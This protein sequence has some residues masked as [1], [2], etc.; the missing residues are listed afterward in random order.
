MESRREISIA[1]FEEGAFQYW[2]GA[3]TIE[4]RDENYE[5]Y[6]IKSDDYFIADMNWFNQS[7]LKKSLESRREI[8]IALF[9]EGAFQYWSGAKTIEPQTEVLCYTPVK[10]LERI[11][12]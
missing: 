9:E 1:L 8:S 2:S 5:L 3:K 6:K 10:I 12:I 4:P 7:I 11:P